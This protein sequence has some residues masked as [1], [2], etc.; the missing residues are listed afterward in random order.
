MANATSSEPAGF[1]CAF[2]QQ[3]VSLCTSRLFGNADRTAGTDRAADEKTARH[4]AEI[5]R[6]R[7]DGM[8]GARRP[9]C[10]WSR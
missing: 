7:R 4:L 3:L 9:T 8:N 10:C 2:C 6:L 5:R 1:V